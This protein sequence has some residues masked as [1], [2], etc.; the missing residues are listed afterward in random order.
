MSLSKFSRVRE[1]PRGSN[2][3]VGKV[4]I[5]MSSQP[6]VKVK[7]DNPD[8]LLIKALPWAAREVPSLAAIFLY[9]CDIT[10]GGTIYSLAVIEVNGRSLLHDN[11]KRLGFTVI[12]M[13]VVVM[14]MI[15]MIMGYIW[16]LCWSKGI[17]ISLSQQLSVYNNCRSR[18]QMGPSMT[19]H[20]SASPEDSTTAQYNEQL[21]HRRGTKW[22]FYWLHMP[23]FGLLHLAIY[24]W[25]AF[26]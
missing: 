25:W 1:I 22:T 15:I 6:F 12:E 5:V 10:W 21:E 4:S 19:H 9:W 11:A 3:K 17:L 7:V 14:M 26:L 20:T 8:W 2:S 16:Y 13:V 24:T 18:T 23:L